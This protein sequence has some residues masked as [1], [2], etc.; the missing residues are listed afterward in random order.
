MARRSATAII[1]AGLFLA[2]APRL[3]AQPTN[4]TEV[5]AL[6]FAVDGKTL[7]AASLNGEISVW[8]VASG[9]KRR[10]VAAHKEGVYAAVLSTDGKHLIT[11]GGDS[12]IKIWDSD[13]LKVLR[14]I[15]GHRNEVFAVAIAPDGKSI[16]SGGADKTIRVW[17]FATGKSKYTVHGHELRVTA[18]A[19]SPDGKVLASG[20]TCTAVVPGF[21]G[22][23]VHGDQVRLYDAANGQE[24]RKL[25]QRG[26]V[27]AFSSDSKVLAAGGMYM[28]GMPADH[29]VS[30]TGGPRVQV[31]QLSNQRELLAFQGQGSALAFSRDGKLL[32]SAWG[33]R[34]H[35][36]RYIIENDTKHR[37]VSLWEMATGKEALQLAEDGATVVAIAPDGKKLAAGRMHGGVMFWNLAPTGWNAEQRLK[38]LDAK[39]LDRHWEILAADNVAAAYHTIWT[40]SAAGDKTT[41][42]LKG[43][44]R[45]AVPAGPE[46]A[47]HIANLDSPK[48]PVREAAHRDLKKLG[49]IIEGDVRKALAGKVSPEVRKRLHALLDPWERHPANADELRQWRALLIL[50]RIGTQAAR[51]VLSQVGRG[52]SGA[53]LTEEAQ[54][55]LNRI[56]KPGGR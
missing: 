51:E 2:P 10:D 17:D 36:G 43:R 24:L 56:D 47:K 8:D 20:G 18:L 44:L 31:A 21:F 23:T 33:S 27:L 12:L 5:T 28:S 22:G 40:L 7:Y 9:T 35:L 13:S 4:C 34:Q 16:A 53:W 15:D 1:L 38:N 30:V 55:A 37:R 54:A 25:E 19:F 52:A 3:E 6:V 14:T 26:T 49:G 48:Y 11:A 46:V 50:E 42:W 41:D 39:E 45:P 32:A 29:G